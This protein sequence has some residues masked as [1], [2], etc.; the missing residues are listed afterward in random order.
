MAEKKNISSGAEKAEKLALASNSDGKAKKTTGAKKTT[1]TVKSEKTEAKSGVKSTGKKK[2]ASKKGGNAVKSEK[3]VKKNRKDNKPLSEKRAMKAKRREEKKI[4]RAK[5]AA[6]RK[7]S[8][9]ERKLAHKEARLEKI[10]ALHDKREER[11][12]KR[13]ERRDLIKSESKEARR[14]RI[15]E[16]RQAKREAH[17]AKH[18]AY[19]ADRKAKRE[20]RLK[21]RAEKRAE[22]ND[23]SKRRT[24]GFGG[25]LAAVISLGV[26][27]LALGTVLTFGW[28]NMDNMQAEMATGY[29]HSL[30][31][32]NSVIDNLDADLSRAKASSSARDR[33]RV[34]SDIA[35]ESQTAETILERF[36]V[37]MQMTEQ[38][39]SFINKMGDSAKQMLYTV[40]NGGE[41][42]ASQIASLNYMYETNA[43]VKE[44]LNTLVTTCDGKDMLK[45]MRGKSSVLGNGFTTI[46]NNTFEDPKGIQDGPFSDSLKKTNPKALKG[47]KEIT[48]QAAEKLAKQYFADYKV[49]EATCTGEATG[50]ALTLYNVNLKTPDGEMFVQLS[51][52]GGKVVA[53]DSYKDCTKN[54]FSVER[55][56]DIAEDFLASIG[57]A[58]LKPVWTNEN[59]T[60]CNLNFAPVQS[61]AV[62]YPD[63]VKVKVCEERGIV[64]G[65]E[66][67]SYVLNHGERNIS[68]PAISEGQAKASINGNM[69]IS[70][71][72]T[73]VIPFD[74]GE[75]MCYEF[76]GELDGNEYY[77]YVD[78]ATGEE[79]EVLT[80]IGTA[81]GRALM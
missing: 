9:L 34:L 18:E 71:S 81:Q 70:S 15:A 65:V 28:L 68:K 17:K 66:A 79:I 24:P 4:E 78:A 11:R 13:K 35:I 53:F 59:G 23:R 37:D 61:G 76:I 36:P 8:R 12:E 38:L 39:S 30:Y 55:C 10:S 32:L 57:Y 73:A 46:Q 80:V 27:T 58:G 14:E 19:L 63:L 3:R 21:V 29:T 31:E 77:V 6:D 49:S 20:H 51:K 64:T 50:E 40:A 42:T 56:I 43:K 74:G 62:I 26:T 22:R 52:L 75:I 45:A 48:A 25:W 44:E 54:N 1:T 72:R 69:E 33:V 7:Q 5:I 41:L 47:E 67:L 16:E 60:T 2:T